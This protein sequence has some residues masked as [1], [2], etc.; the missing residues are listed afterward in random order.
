MSE[1]MA[2]PLTKPAP[3]FLL[4]PPEVR[5]CI[6]DAALSWP[7]ISDLAKTDPLEPDSTVHGHWE[8]PLCTVPRPRYGPMS[9]PSLLLLNRQITPEALEV[10]YRKP[11]ILDTTPPYIPQLGQP[12]GIPEIISET[13][14]Q[15]LRFVVPRMDL[16]QRQSARYWFKI[17]EMLLDIWFV[18]N[19]LEEVQARIQ[20]PPHQGDTRR[21]R[22]AEEIRAEYYH[23]LLSKLR[24]FGEQVPVII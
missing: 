2:L 6:Y 22:Y 24:G 23:R 3:S 13:T 17:I 19:N 11:L 7:V 16:D 15:N 18:K 8:Q 1:D 4:L 21:D 14:L 10:L 5:D 20:C 9:T 12:M